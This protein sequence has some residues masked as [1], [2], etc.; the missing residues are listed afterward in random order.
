MKHSVTYTPVA[1]IYM[2]IYFWIKSREKMKRKKEIFKSKFGPVREHCVSSRWIVSRRDRLETI[3]K[4]FR[5]SLSNGDAFFLLSAFDEHRVSLSLSL[6]PSRRNE[7]GDARKKEDVQNEDDIKMAGGGEG[8]AGGA[9]FATRSI[10]TT[11]RRVQGPE[12]YLWI[13]IYA[14]LNGN[15]KKKRKKKRIEEERRWKNDE[16]KKNLIYW[17]FKD[18]RSVSVRCKFYNEDK[19]KINIYIYTDYIYI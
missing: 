17:R 9:H 2:Y 13:F 1:Y 7:N 10:G 19:K 15:E 12:M 6:C 5:S 14:R 4:F 11:Q 16:R 18:R 8:V 3:R